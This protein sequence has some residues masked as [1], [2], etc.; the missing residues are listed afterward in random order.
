[1]FSK[2][3]VWGTATSSYQIEGKRPGDGSGDCVWDS[4]C[5]SGAIYENHNGDVAC[6]H[7]NRYEDDFKMMK[8]LNIKAYRFSIN[9]ARLIP[10]GIGDV[11]EKAVEMYRNMIIKMRENGIEPYMTLYHWELPQ[12]LQD[13]GGW[14]NEESCRWFG[15]LAKVVA[16]RFSDIC[17]YYFT[18]NEPQC[19]VG[20]GYQS[21]EN[22]PGLKLSIEDG[23]KIAHNVLKAH[24]I[25]VRMLRKFSVR[26]V[27]VGYAP[28]AGVAYPATESEAD[29]EAARKQY[30][31]FG[32]DDASWAWNVSW[33]SD[34]VILGHYP[35]EGMERFA[36]YLPEITKEDMELIHQ[37]IDFLGQNI[38]NG[39]TVRADEE[40][41]PVFVKR[42]E[43]FPRTAIDWPVTPEALYWG[44]R[45]LYERYGLPIY[46]TENGMS[47]HDWVTPDGRVHDP[48]R[49]DFLDKY[50]GNIQRACDEG[51][52]V[53][54]YFLWSFMDNFEWTRGYDERFGIVYVDFRNQKRIAKDSALWYRDT[55]AANGANLSCNKHNR[56]LIFLEPVFKEMIW[57]GNRLKSEFGY[58]IPGDDTGECWGISAHP[59]GDC[60]VQDGE[61]AGKKLSWLWKNKPEIFGQKKNEGVFPLLT[62]IIDAKADLSIQ[63]HP[64]DEYARQHE[65]GSLGKTECWYIMDCPEE[66]TLVVGH[67]ATTRRQLEN[68]IQE[69]KWN[70]LIREVP[71]KRGDFIQIIPGTVHAIKAGILLLETQQNSDIT[72]R[73]YDYDR[74]SNG[75]KRELHVDKSID[76][77]NV[78]ARSIKEAVVNYSE[79]KK[80]TMVLMQECQYYKVW[81]IEVQG[82][83]E[84]EQKQPFMLMSVVS[85]SGMING[86]YIKK[87]SH[88][89]IPADYG[90]V[91][92]IGEMEIIASAI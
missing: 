77:I 51:I 56:E 63:V 21:G 74:L 29:I 3:F 84:F 54:G 72:Y 46:I 92:L 44:P 91:T 32:E 64:E 48:N 6:D 20:L 86:T 79:V 2:D 43:G 50:L 67:N 59:H 11:N 4:F 12:A 10:E 23:F 7:I 30:F 78:P 87:G 19:F 62:K 75:K 37:P 61:F 71:V 28:T 8:Y 49:I 26:P 15:Y 55:I 45:F 42:Y 17:E 80:N 52:P 9:W 22:A 38:Y 69:G 60:V 27:K 76:V 89:I 40:G 58:D 66:A 36:K 1:M 82:E 73:V 25:A 35:Q 39:Y 33:F 90:N 41:N 53:V 31:G 47:A 18:L 13:E 68:M 16:E 70:E 81:K 57:G 83:M 88:F 85:G 24:G 65:D 5:R 34:P 14:L